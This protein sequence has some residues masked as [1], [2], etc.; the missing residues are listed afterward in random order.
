MEGEQE[1]DM[2]SACVQMVASWIQNEQ[3][4][5]LCLLHLKIQFIVI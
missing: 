5:Y 2:G 4:N 3:T 1:N